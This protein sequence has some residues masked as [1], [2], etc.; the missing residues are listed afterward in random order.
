MH[1]TDEYY[2]I[3]EFYYWEPQH[4]G[5]KKNPQNPKTIE[6]I[7]EKLRAKE[8]PLNHLLNIYLKLLSNGALSSLFSDYLPSQ[9]K[10]FILEGRD[11]VDRYK[12][13]YPDFVNFSQ[14][15]V[16]LSSD[17]HNVFI[18]LK[19]G[20]K[21]SMEQYLK[22]LFLHCLDER[23]HRRMKELVIIYSAP[24]ALA[25]ITKEKF[26]STDSFKRAVHI[27][28]ELSGRDISD[29]QRRMRELHNQ[30]HLVFWSFDEVIHRIETL[31]L[32]GDAPSHALESYQ[33]LTSGMI[34]EF[35]RR[36]VAVSP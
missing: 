1:W 31:L 34:R 29:Y 3:M 5:K 36:K 4:I 2:E 21:T 26:E 12:A 11:I 9:P 19:V 17:S 10:E 22:Y 20:S 8:V 18:E 27:G 30:S 33:K 16:F 24:K 23:F 15:D 14:P 25:S 7:H 13:I 6:Q 28:D 35:K 32:H